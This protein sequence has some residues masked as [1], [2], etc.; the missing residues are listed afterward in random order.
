MKRLHKWTVTLLATAALVTIVVLATGSGAAIAA[1]VDGV[2]VTNT[3]SDPVPVAQQV[4]TK[5]MTRLLESDTPGSDSF[6]FPEIKASLITIQGD[7]FGGIVYVAV[8]S[9][10]TTVLS[11]KLLPSE[12]VVLPLSQPLPVDEVA[13]TA[14]F[15]RTF[16]FADFNIVGS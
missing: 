8:K 11:F 5:H 3:P 13:T 4:A 7:T 10:G 12:R 15:V 14:C 16:C 2:F 6:S 1:K 9:G